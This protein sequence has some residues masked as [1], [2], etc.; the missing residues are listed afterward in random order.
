MSSAEK[1]RPFSISSYRLWGL[2]IAFLLVISWLDKLVV[3]VPLVGDAAV[4]L[5]CISAGV[6]AFF[7]IITSKRMPS[8]IWTAIILFVALIAIYLLG[9]FFSPLPSSRPVL[10]LVLLMFFFV[11][12]YYI[13][14]HEKTI[15][16]IA[17][18]WVL[19]ALV[20]GAYWIIKGFP[21]PFQGI[22]AQKN[23]LGGATLF[24]MFFIF[25]GRLIS[26][27]KRWWNLGLLASLVVLLASG[28]RSGWL[29]LVV[30][31]LVYFLWPHMAVKKWTFPLVFILAFLASLAVIYVYVGLTQWS[32]FPRLTA[33]VLKYTHQNLYSG[34][35]VLWPVLINAVKQHPWGYGPGANPDTFVTVGLSSH[36]LYLQVLLQTGYIG[37]ASLGAILFYI[38]NRL[39]LIHQD[40]IVRLAAAFLIGIL[41]HESFEVSLIQNNLT[42][43]IVMWTI[44]A[45]GCGRLLVM[46][47]KPLNS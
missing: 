18:I 33:L 32:E 28:S 3:P 9:N 25:A 4:F 2:W 23:M 19:L 21:Y 8:V 36:N 17:H 1:N 46:Q 15:I 27:S 14:P 6:Y 13:L 35:Q 44:L 10:E 20:N 42:I 26:F 37:L 31:A 30:I 16:T 45:I 39:Y 5:C 11:G 34:R 22:F 7:R 40:R 47:Q 38:W 41:I 29:A 24:G 12:A 43:G